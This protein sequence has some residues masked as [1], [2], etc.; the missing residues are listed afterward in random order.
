MFVSM[1]KWW[2]R[3]NHAYN[4]GQP[5]SRKKVSLKIGMLCVW[6]HFRCKVGKT[7]CKGCDDFCQT[8]C[9]WTAEH[10]ITWQNVTKTHLLCPGRNS[11]QVVPATT[12][13]HNIIKHTLSS[14]QGGGG[15]DTEP[16][17]QTIV[18]TNI[19]G[20]FH[21]LKI[22]TVYTDWAFNSSEYSGHINGNEAKCQ[23]SSLFRSPRLQTRTKPISYP[24]FPGFLVSGSSPKK[25]LG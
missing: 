25:T 15:G 18:A 21:S 19:K 14:L 5:I 23:D 3:N 4:A 10:L 12:H 17:I 6:A 7:R 22:I 24:E 16:N 20:R 11:I 9:T 1:C 2:K 13:G 8:L